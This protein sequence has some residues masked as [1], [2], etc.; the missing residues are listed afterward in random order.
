MK[1]LY[2]IILIS[3]VL[4]GINT[5]AQS[6]YSL[7][8][9]P[10]PG[11]NILK[12]D[13]DTTG[14]V[15]GLAGGAQTW[16]FGLL[17]PTGVTRT[18]QYVDPSST[19]YHSSFPTTNLGVI[20][21]G[22]LGSTG[23]AYYSGNNSFIDFMGLVSD[24]GLGTV[25]TYPYSDPIRTLIFPFTFNSTFSDTYYGYSTFIVS[26]ITIENYKA[27]S[28]TLTG[29]A[30]GTITTPGGTYSNVLRVKAENHSTDSTI[31]SGLSLVNFL[32]STGYTWLDPNK[33]Y[34]IFKIGYVTNGMQ[35]TSMSVE[36]STITTG[37]NETQLKP[38]AI[39]PNPAINT[40]LVHI[41]ADQ[42]MDGFA[43]FQAIDLSGKEVKR[44]EFVL[45][46]ASHKTV[47]I[48]MKDCPAGIYFIRLSQK[49]AV[50]TSRFVKE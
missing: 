2:I 16:N 35:P 49:D 12:I 21:P 33:I 32:E 19:P 45:G 20:V 29:D 17:S 44:I 48:D 34:D 42:L 36:Y 18:D 10:T 9:W 13:L 37:I 28:L 43:T 41:S 46:T 24:D 15:P 5:F 23:Y 25:N 6:T 22:S 8:K 40:S 7:D 1:K 11:T 14:V 47:D 27:G 30:Y 38:L 39:Y 31:Y 50:Y 4:S 3:S 26:G